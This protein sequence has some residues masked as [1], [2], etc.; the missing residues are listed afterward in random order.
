MQGKRSLQELMQIFRYRLVELRSRRSM[1][2]RM[3]YKHTYLK[4][5]L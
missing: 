1:C 3:I 5:F 4:A 2:V